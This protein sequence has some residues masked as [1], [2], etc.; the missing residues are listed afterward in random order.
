MNCGQWPPNLP[1]LREQ[2]EPVQRHARARFIAMMDLDNYGGEE[3]LLCIPYIE[4]TPGADRLKSLCE[5]LAELDIDVG[6][7]QPIHIS[8]SFGVAPLDPNVPVEAWI[9][10]ADKASNSAKSPGRN[11]VRVW[12]RAM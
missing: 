3:F 12:D 9:D 4:E 7:K 10:R 5:G 1:T 6:G 11:C 8:A 2:Q